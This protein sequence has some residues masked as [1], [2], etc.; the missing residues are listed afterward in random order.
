MFLKA[1][2]EGS[3]KGTTMNEK[4]QSFLSMQT[5][6]V[7]IDEAIKNYLEEVTAT[8]A[9]TNEQILAEINKNF[10][11]ANVMDLK[12]G[13]FTGVDQKLISVESASYENIIFSG[14]YDWGR[15]LI[16]N[17]R[18]NGVLVSEQAIRL[19]ALPAILMP[20][21]TVTQEV[22][23]TQVT[24]VTAPVMSDAE[25]ISRILLIKKMKNNGI[26]VAD[27]SVWVED[28]T[29]GY[30]MIDEA[31][32]VSNPD[33]KFSLSYKNKENTAYEITVHTPTGDSQISDELDITALAAKVQ[34][35]YEGAAA[36]QNTQ[37]QNP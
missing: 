27:S 17:I 16:S 8:P 14:Q 11:Q 5:Q 20:K 30:F 35:V 32:L 13:S 4:Y 24:Q 25:K 15:K 1:A 29:K 23:A 36:A 21:G 6:Q 26:T 3:L 31:S 10:E 34:G 2:K 12:L 33:I 37:T 7:L 19:D 18:S 9:V 22:T 28:L